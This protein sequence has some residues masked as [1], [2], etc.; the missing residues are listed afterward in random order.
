MKELLTRIIQAQ[1]LADR[2]GR[3]VLLMTQIEGHYKWPE[4]RSMVNRQEEIL[5]EI[6]H[7]VAAAAD[8]PRDEYRQAVSLDRLTKILQTA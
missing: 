6:V 3:A 5:R 8:E 2:Y 4:F 1:S 7:A